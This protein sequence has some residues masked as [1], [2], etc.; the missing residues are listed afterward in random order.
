MKVNTHSSAAFLLSFFALFVLSVDRLAGS[1]VPVPSESVI[2]TD[3]IGRSITEGVDNGYFGSKWK[4]TFESGEIQQLIILSKNVYDD[5]C[6]F[7]VAMTLKSESSPT[8]YNATVQVD[9]SLVKNRWKLTTVMSKGVRV[10]DSG[11]YRDCISTK[12][13]SDGWGGVDCLKIKNNI[14]SALLVGG[15]IRTDESDEWHKFSLV[16]NGTTTMG[17]GGTFNYG[18][19]VDYRIHFVELF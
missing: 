13:D 10:V 17:V 1:N 4:W 3:L 5:Y 9:Y 8:R 7:V 14:D 18:S 2:A 6:S 16:I 19:V 11:R 12:I 15:V